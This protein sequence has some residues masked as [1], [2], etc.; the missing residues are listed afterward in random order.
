MTS[1][2]APAVNF[3][4]P[5]V[6]IGLVAVVMFVVVFQVADT[7]WMPLH[8]WDES[9]LAVNAIEMY[10]NKNYI[11]TTYDFE[12]DLWNTKPPLLI[13]FM[14]M[15]MHLFGTTP[16]ALRLPSVI[17]AILTVFLVIRMVFT[18]TDSLFAGCFAGLLLLSHSVFNG[19]HGGATGD[20]DALLTLFTT[21]YGIVLFHLISSERRLPGQAALAGVL[22]GLAILTKGV[23]GLVPGIGIAAYALV[24]TLSRLWRKLPDYFLVIGIGVGIGFGFYFARSLYG[25]DYIDSVIY[26]EPGR[27]SNSLTDQGSRYD[28]YVRVLIGNPLDFRKPWFALPLALGVFLL[29]P[30]RMR[31]LGIFAMFQ[32]A[33]LII[34]LSLAATKLAWY[35][36]PA[37]PWIAV[38]VAIGGCAIYRAIALGG[39]RFGWLPTR[40]APILAALFVIGVT[41]TAVRTR[42]L[43]PEKA[44]LRAFGLLIAEA[45]KLGTADSL[46][47]VDGGF[48][49]E[50]GT[51]RYAPTLRF[52]RLAA[53]LSGVSVGEAA[54]IAE[55]SGAKLIGSCDP[56]LQSAVAIAGRVVWRGSGCVIVNR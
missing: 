46:M 23:A 18:T 37:L 45:E 54:T 41:G 5:I 4:D 30:G 25:A 8:P 52:Y 19:M 9:R 55:T 39:N 31:A 42:Y 28:Y 51:D 15:S 13:D 48:P 6:V 44:D 53:G 17:A 11:V 26:N 35:I 50:N 56:A 14:T 12:P 32:S 21:G 24:F 40:S 3:R 36:I 43:Y 2:P 47:V 27:F 10:I 22:V 7:L 16:F 1:A 20:Y 49:H 33:G 29:P 34:V 38:A